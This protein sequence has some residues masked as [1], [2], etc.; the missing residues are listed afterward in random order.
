[1]LSSVNRMRLRSDAVIGMSDS[2]ISDWLRP[3]EINKVINRT[4]TLLLINRTKQLDEL[5]RNLSKGNFIE[6]LK[7]SN[8]RITIGK[9]P[10]YGI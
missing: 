9:L 10:R 3:L 7:K 2:K 8:K 4:F 5:N 1:M 6:N